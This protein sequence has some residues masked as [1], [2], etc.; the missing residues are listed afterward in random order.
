MRRVLPIFTAF[1]LALHRVVPVA[2]VAAV[3]AVAKTTST[4]ARSQ[5]TKTCR[6]EVR[7][8]TWLIAPRSVRRRPNRGGRPQ[9]LPGDMSGGGRAS[10]HAGGAIAGSANSADL[11]QHRQSAWLH[12]FNVR[13]V[14]VGFAPAHARRGPP[15]Q[16]EIG[17]GVQRA[18]T[19]RT[20][21]D[22]CA[23]IVPRVAA[24]ANL[25]VTMNRNLDGTT[26]TSMATSLSA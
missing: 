14:L 8:T 4:L 20:I 21:S 9:S 16:H 18:G 7:T 24:L 26:S 19:T 25:D 6:W 3:A 1:L 11:Q 5:T 13:S 12:S 15:P 17:R 2:E 10:P 22:T 23:G